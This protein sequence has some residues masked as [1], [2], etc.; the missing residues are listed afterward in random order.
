VILPKLYPQTNSNSLVAFSFVHAPLITKP[1]E[2]SL[3]DA[4]TDSPWYGETWLRY[5]L[6]HTLS[7]SHFGYVSRARCEFRIIM[8]EFCYMAYT[9][10]LGVT[11]DKAQ[12][13]R[14][15]LRSWEENL[16]PP[17]SP[18]KIVLPGQ[19]QLQ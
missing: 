14:T 8:N 1:P 5:P 6:D 12:G 17:L 7:P 10:G 18:K 9:D 4:S 13:F 11:I 3:P 15:R 16:P 2:W 19:L